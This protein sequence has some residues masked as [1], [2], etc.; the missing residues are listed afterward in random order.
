MRSEP[1]LYWNKAPGWA[2]SLLMDEDGNLWWHSLRTDETGK[3]KAKLAR[4]VE[5]LVPEDFEMEDRPE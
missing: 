5:D 2:S 3:G 4:G 1:G